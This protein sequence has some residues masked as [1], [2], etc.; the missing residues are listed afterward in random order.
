MMTT[1]VSAYWDVKG[2]HSSNSFHTW[3]QNTLSFNCPYIFFGNQ[4]SIELVKQ[5]RK[6][7]PTHYVL[8]EID[9][10]YSKKFKPFLAPHDIHVPSPEVCMIW[11]EKVLLMEKAKDI[12]PFG[13]EYFLWIDAGICSYRSEHP[14]ITPFDDKKIQSLPKDKFIYC[15]SNEPLLLHF[16]HENHY[17]HHISGATFLLHISFID[18]FV[19][20]YLSTL[21]R[22]INH[23]NWV[24]TEQ[25]ILTHMIQN[26][27][28]LFFKHGEGY[29]ALISLLY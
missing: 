15:S 20:Q 25:K 21:D 9:D 7:L 18:T 17:Y 12:N 13:S 26:D 3:F 28:D 4:Q 11:L 29:G 22:Y 16:I 8:L 14:P 6:D 27:P 5:Y 24:N 23:Y 19:K 2:K 1:V 10:F